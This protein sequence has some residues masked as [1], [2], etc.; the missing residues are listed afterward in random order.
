MEIEEDLELLN[1]Q[2]CGL[3]LIRLEGMVLFQLMR[4]YDSK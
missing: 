2:F 4:H 3:E 1:A